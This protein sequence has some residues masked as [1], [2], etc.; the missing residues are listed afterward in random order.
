MGLLSSKAV[1]LQHSVSNAHGHY[2]A[3]RDE[4]CRMVARDNGFDPIDISATEF[5]WDS[6]GPSVRTDS[7]PMINSDSD[8]MIDEH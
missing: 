7:D 1:N 4:M 3:K 5:Q 8:P 6:S 2:P